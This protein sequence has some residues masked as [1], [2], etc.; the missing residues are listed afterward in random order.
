MSDSDLASKID[1]LESIEQIKALK[2]KYFRAL[3]QQLFDQ[4][5]GLFT[6]DGVIDYGEAGIYEQITD[7]V[8]MITEYAKTNTAAGVHKGYNAEIQVNGDAAT[9]QWMCDF[10]SVDNSNGVSYHQTGWYEDTY[11]R[12]DGVWRI[13]RTM[14]RPLFNETTTVNENNVAV[15]LG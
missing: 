15:S 8:K 11:A 13:Q 12:V 5:E 10:H 9:G 4:V 6:A 1:A 14:N 2:F 7:F 3:D